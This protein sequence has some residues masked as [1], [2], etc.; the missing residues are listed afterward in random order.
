MVDP[1]IGF[2]SDVI[3]DPERFVGRTELIGD[4]IRALNSKTGLISVYGKRGVGKSSLLRQLQIMA[5]GDYSLATSAGLAHQVPEKPRK[6]L[7]VYYQCDALIADGR[8]LIARLCNDQDPDDGLLRLI[9]NDGKEIVEFARSK[10][11]HAGADLKVV[12]WG[13]KGVESSKYAR[14][15]PA[16]PIQTFRNF[17]SAIVTH[18][19]KAKMGR[20]ALLVLLDEFDVIRDK[21]GIGSLIKS[22]SSETVKFAVCGVAKDLGA[23]VQDHASVERL[24]EGGALKVRPMPKHESKD[25]VYRAELLFDGEMTFEVAATDRIA[26]LC[27]G[28]PYLVQ[29]LGKA[30]VSKANEM[31]RRRV[32]VDL[33]DRVLAD[34]KTGKAFPT[35]E[36]KYQ[37]AIGDADARQLLLTLLAEQPE[38]NALFNDDLGKVVLRKVRPD[39]DDLG[40]QYVDQLMPRLVD[41]KYGPALERV[42]ERQGIYEFVDPVFRLYVRLRNL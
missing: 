5:L 24:L 21:S 4:C 11:V 32:T 35:L 7:T 33:L 15:V 10:E 13:A 25:I 29:M 3:K 18:Q 20:D 8:E 12:N 1:E 9:P 14:V 27:E 22:M 23:L 31:G 41:R 30:C 37:L 38:E 6:Y 19:V 39:A 26:F 16:D 2:T 36:S 34:V 28:Y 17:V 42:D 40:I